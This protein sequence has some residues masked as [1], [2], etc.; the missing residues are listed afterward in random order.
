MGK[1]NR[2]AFSDATEDEI[3]KAIKNS[4]SYSAA[5]MLLGFSRGGAGYRALKR[6]VDDNKIDVSHFKGCMFRKGVTGTQ[7]RDPSTIFKVFSLLEKN[8]PG[9]KTV[10]IH[11]LRSGRE[12]VCEDCGNNGTWRGKVLNLILFYRNGDW[13]DIRMENLALLC[14]NCKFQKRILRHLE[15]KEQQDIARVA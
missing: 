4:I 10:K 7:M 2:R 1:N 6:Y 13:R 15:K 12:Y 8:K 11:L 14:P 9:D 3:R 5:T